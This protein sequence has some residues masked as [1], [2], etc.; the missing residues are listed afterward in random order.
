[1]NAFGRLGKY[2]SEHINELFK[3]KELDKIDWSRVNSEWIGR[4]ISAQGKIINNEDSIVKI[5][6]FIKKSL[7]LTLSKEEMVKE[8]D[9]RR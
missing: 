2:F 5:C 1:M 3:L 4:A 7:G 8:N 9:I 6:N